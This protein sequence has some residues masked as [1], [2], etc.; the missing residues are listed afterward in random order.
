[1]LTL[2]PRRVV[3]SSVASPA[4]HYVINGTVFG[5]KLLSIKCVFCFSLKL[6][7]EIFLL[8]RKPYRDIIN[9]HTCSCE[10]PIILVRF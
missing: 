2:F 1:M 7:R 8:L 9:V 3:L 10:V 4:L 5:K 6:L